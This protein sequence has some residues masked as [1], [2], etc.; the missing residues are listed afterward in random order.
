MSW[1]S[2][3]FL[4]RRIYSDLSEEIQQHLSEKVEALMAEG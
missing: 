2:R 4:R 1:F 3:F